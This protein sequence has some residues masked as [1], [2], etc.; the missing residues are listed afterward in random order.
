[1]PAVVSAAQTTK[2]QQQ[3]D[4]KQQHVDSAEQLQ[5]RSLG[6]DIRQ[7]EGRQREAKQPVA[8]NIQRRVTWR[9][10]PGDHRQNERKDHQNQREHLVA[11]LLECTP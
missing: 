5:P 6:E 3:H 9:P 7:E 2:E 4:Q 1:M 8:Q 10:Q 11:F